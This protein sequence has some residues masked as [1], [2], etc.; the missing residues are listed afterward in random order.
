[1]P[2]KEVSLVS[3]RSEF[4]DHARLPGANIAQLARRFGIARK[5]AYKW[6]ARQRHGLS[7]RDA[8]RTPHSSPRRTPPA[9]EQRVLELRRQYPTWAGPA[10]GSASS[11][12]PPTTCGR[13]TARATSPWPT[14][15]AATR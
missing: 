11:T 1:M 8:T 14:V 15:A 4:L 2:W 9:L 12:P 5:T 7:L 3:A 6:L 13:W 10:T